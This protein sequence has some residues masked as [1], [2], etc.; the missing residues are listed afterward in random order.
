MKIVPIMKGIAA[1]A[2]VG[3]ACYI[4]SKSPKRQKT[5]LKKS[6]ERTVRSFMT[7]LDVSSERI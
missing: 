4:I 7:V 5:A 1:G 2:T 3:T 6:A